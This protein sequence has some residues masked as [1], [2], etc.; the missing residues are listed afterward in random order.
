M[1]ETGMALRPSIIKV[2]ARRLSLS[3]ANKNLDEGLNWLMTPDDNAC[4]ILVE[5]IEGISEQGSSSGGNQ[6]AV[7]HLTP[8]GQIA[9]QVL[10]GK[11]SKVNEYDFSNKSP[12]FT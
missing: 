10:T 5:E 12:F 1:G 6:P 3:E 4:P 8:D 11:I 7:Y 2:M 9:Y